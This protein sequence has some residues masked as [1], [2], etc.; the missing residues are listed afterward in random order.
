VRALPTADLFLQ[1]FFADRRRGTAGVRRDRIDR[2]EADLRLAVELV[3]PDGL[4][5][6]LLI[7]L[8]AEREFAPVAAVARVLPVT[9]LVAVLHRYLTDPLYRPHA[10]D[11]ARDR[12][13]T[14]AALIRRLAGEPELLPET[15]RLRRLDERVRMELATLQPPRGRLRLRRV[16]G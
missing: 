13:D 12:L 11:E 6:D 16:R 9:G 10:V 5:A 15:R 8:A 3:E 7:L 14:C 2:A 4:D 1:E